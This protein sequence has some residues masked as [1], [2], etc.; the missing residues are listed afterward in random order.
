[1]QLETSNQ[2]SLNQDVEIENQ[3]LSFAQAG[4]WLSQYRIICIEL[5]VGLFIGLIFVANNVGAGASILSG[6]AAGALVSYIC[7]VF[8]KNPLKP[9]TNIR[10]LGQALVGLTIG[11]SIAHNNLTE[12]GFKLPI[13]ILITLLLLLSSVLIGYAYSK[14]SKI[15]LLSAL[16]AVTPGNIGVMASLAADYGR[17]VALISLVQVMRFTTIILVV[18]A[19]ANVSTPHDVKVLISS[20]TQNLFY[21][22]P[23]YLL[24]LTLVL[25]ITLSVARLGGKFKIPAAYLLCSILVGILFKSVPDLDFS[26]PPLLNLAG[27]TLLGITIG[28]Y[29]GINPNLGKRAIAYA[30]IPV[31]LTIAGGFAIAGTLTMFTHW[32]WLTCLLM[33]SPGGS[34]EMILIALV[35]DHNVEIVTAAHLVRLIAINLY[36]PLLLW[37]WEKYGSDMVNTKTSQPTQM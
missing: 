7:R 16:L 28:E 20:L 30:T 11:F 2:S 26:L 33:V 17:D 25:T 23:S 12:I 3:K 27:Q 19:I 13:L 32:D 35:L 18:P 24:L 37:A 29:W 31:I 36:L 1:M 6:I 4:I 22:N 15:E 8:F 9:N 34:P 14:L 10:K 21:W 5:I